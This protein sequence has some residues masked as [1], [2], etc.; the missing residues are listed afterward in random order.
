MFYALAAGLFFH[1]YFLRRRFL[2]Q[3]SVFRC[4]R[5]FFTAPCPVGY[6]SP[7]ISHGCHIFIIEERAAAVLQYKYVVSATSSE[8]RERPP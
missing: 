3:I 5:F 4:M 6:F 7:N 8:H 2:K 1:F